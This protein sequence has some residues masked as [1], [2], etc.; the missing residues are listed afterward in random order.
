MWNYTLEYVIQAL[1]I[2]LEYF[3]QKMLYA[4]SAY[5]LELNLDVIW[6]L[7]STAIVTVTEL[8][9]S[10]LKNVISNLEIC[11]YSIDR[12]MQRLTVKKAFISVPVTLMNT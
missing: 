4:S 2:F 6:F 9:V 10:F 7:L 5:V 11:F 8:L 1:K 3:I 12:N